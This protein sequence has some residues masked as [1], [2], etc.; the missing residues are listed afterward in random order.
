M[1]TRTLRLTFPLD[2]RRTLGPV[3]R[4]SGDPTFRWAQENCWRATR[5]PEG[6]ASVALRLV[7][8][9]LEAQAWGPGAERALDAL[10]RLIG[11]E[12]R[13][14]EFRPRHPLLIRLHRRFERMRIGRTDAVVEALVPSI[15]EQK[16]T[17]LEAR[18]AYRRLILTYGEPAPGPPGLHLPPDPRTLAAVP[19]H[20][21]HV[22][23]VERKRAD[24]IRQA[25]AQAARLEALAEGDAA[26]AQKALATIRGVG[27]WT[28]AEVAAVAMGDPD[29][30]P[31]GDYHIPSLV[32]W[33]LAGERAGTDGRM[34]ELLEP[35]AGH[36]GRVIRLLGAG[37]LGPPRR[38][39]RSAPRHIA[40]L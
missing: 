3:R 31:V 15:L 18:R 13:P 28:A 5:T 12:D 1:P 16:V 37:G 4:G 39:P 9:T 25:C 36:R 34:L 21:L 35:F 38:G 40:H 7:A 33:A 22:L 19:Y 32:T 24:T 8:G 2:L 29:A 26:T 20:D 17:G 10:P 14:A 30:V 27:P 11:C 23:G 6:P